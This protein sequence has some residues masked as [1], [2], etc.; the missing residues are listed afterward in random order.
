[1]MHHL[2]ICLITGR[3]A[4]DSF[5]CGDC[6]PCSAAHHVPEPVRRLLIERDEFMSKYEA[7]ACHLDAFKALADFDKNGGTSLEDVKRELGLE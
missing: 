4:G 6:D 2:P 7:A 5:A 3:I 1:M